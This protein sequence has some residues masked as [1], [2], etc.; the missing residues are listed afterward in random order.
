MRVHE[1]AAAAVDAVTILVGSAGRHAVLAGHVR[2]LLKLMLAM[3]E[4]ALVTE[5]AGT[6]LLP[7]LAQFGL[8]LLLE[9]W[10]LVRVLVIVAALVNRLRD[11][12]WHKNV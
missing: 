8:L 3:S 4:S 2:L 10:F 11:E 9:G 7:E 1:L 6:G 12:T 5:L